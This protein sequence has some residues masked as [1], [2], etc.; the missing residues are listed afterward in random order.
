M[1]GI[2]HV[3]QKVKENLQPKLRLQFQKRWHEDHH[4][5]IFKTNQLVCSHLLIKLKEKKKLFIQLWL[6]YD[7]FSSLLVLV[8]VF[9]NRQGGCRT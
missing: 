6:N 2:Q 9:M 5:Y 8:S 4:T 1:D 7:I 3:Q